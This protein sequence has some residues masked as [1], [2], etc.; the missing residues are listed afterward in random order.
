[1]EICF[2]EEKDDSLTNKRIKELEARLADMHNVVED[3]QQQLT[4]TEA[5]LQAQ[6]FMRYNSGTLDDW[7]WDVYAKEMAVYYES[8]AEKNQEF[9]SEWAEK[10]T[11]QW[12]DSIKM[13][14]FDW[15]TYAAQWKQYFKEMEEYQEHQYGRGYNVFFDTYNSYADDK[16]DRHVRT[17]K[18]KQDCKE[19]AYVV[20][21][22]AAEQMARVQLEQARN[23]ELKEKVLEDKEKSFEKVEKAVEKELLK[24]RYIDQP[25][26]YVFKLTSNGAYIN[27]EK[28]PEKDFKKYSELIERITKKD[29][30]E[31]LPDH[32]SRLF[33]AN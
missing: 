23:L 25:N 6:S 16:K 33:I 13:D 32:R 15:T 22:N 7:D 18:A 5:H 4:E 14:D 2:T 12:K 27:D 3:L 8:H 28:M 26:G 21:I 29:I 20:R 1:M 11:E 24:D 19:L 17:K 31:L 9:W 30:E 10:Y